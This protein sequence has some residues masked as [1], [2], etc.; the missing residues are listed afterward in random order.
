LNIR[1]DISVNG[2]VIFENKDLIA[3][4]SNDNKTWDI[5][6]EQ[7]QRF[8]LE[9]KIGEKLTLN[10][11]QDSEADFN[12]ENDLTIKWQGDK[13]DIL[14]L[15]EAGNINLSLPSTQFV[16]VG[17]GKSE[18]LFGLKTI[19]QFGPLEIQSIISREQVRK[20]AKSFSGGQTSEWSYINDYNFIK[21]RYFFIEEKFKSQYYPLKINN[22]NLVHSYNPKGIIYDYEIYKKSIT[23]NDDGV[24]D[25]VYG[26]AFTN[27]QDS[28]S[29]Q[30]SGNWKKLIEGQDYE[31]DRLL[32]FL[33]L[34]TVSSQEAVAICY[35][36]GD[37]DY[38]TGTFIKDSTISNGTD[39]VLIYDI[40]KDPNYNGS[41]ENCDTDLD[42]ILNEEGDDYEEFNGNP[43]FQPQ[44]PK[45]INMKL[46]KL[47]SPTTPNYDTWSLMFKNVYSLG[48]SISDLN[49]LELDVV[50]NNAGLEETHS[51][52]NNFQSFLTIFGLDTRNSNGDELI[53]PTNE[54]YLGDGKV[55]NNTVLIKPVYGEL[56]LPSHLPFAYDN[57]PRTDYF[58]GCD[59]T[60]DGTPDFYGPPQECL[61]QDSGIIIDEIFN[62][63]DFE[64][65]NIY[66]GINSND[67]DYYLD[68]DLEDQDNNFSNADSGPAMYYSV[69]NQEIISEHEFMIKYKHSSGNSTIDLGG[70]MIVEG[71]ETVTLNGTILSRGIDYT[72]DYFTGNINFINSD[73]ML[74]GANINIT[75][76]ENELISVDQKLL[77]GTHMKYGFNSQNF[78][79]GGVFFYD[80]S[81]MDKNVEI[82]YEPMRNFIW[83]I[84]GRYE[85]EIEKIT[86]AL[87]NLPFIEASAPS[88]ITFEGEFAEV[89]P[90]PNPLG[91]G[92]LDD[93]EASKRSVSLN[94]SA[95]NWKTSSAPFDSLGNI[96]S[97]ESKQ[98]MIWY[99]P[100]N[101]I[102]QQ[103]FGL[104][105]K[106]QVKQAT[107][108]LKHYG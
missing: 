23:S 12:W 64:N 17:S 102:Q 70:F 14:Q 98:D 39:L 107:H 84:N 88:K 75:Y 37:Y 32:G 101:E 94:L 69:D 73:A 13:N 43:G 99:N 30:I 61:A 81:I 2:E 16:S 97:I 54:F 66:H 51:Q 1:G 103:K 48:S 26:T 9:G 28:S 83:N 85:K 57:N 42:G 106:H 41:D 4:N 89:Y 10:A 56:F 90:D 18:G 31:I 96:K 15:A 79:S 21:D 80:Q 34:N 11:T 55:D 92:F 86:E 60:N 100:Y 3:L 58:I 67:L 95:R 65:S 22:G 74:P 93:F 63:T 91:Q 25:I 59:T 52:V 20:S 44:E 33:R 6:I 62:Y 5:D 46:I 29:T 40:C 8:D 104:I 7:T 47:D 78:I 38:L 19:H 53:D 108:I 50:Y 71:S 77:F 76:E 82:G 35:D 24:L 68:T 36:Y 72:I 27:P 49:S 87:N 45:P 105:K